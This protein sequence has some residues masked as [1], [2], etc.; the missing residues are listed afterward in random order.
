MKVAIVLLS[1]AAFASADLHKY[2]TAYGYLT[3]FGIP[4]A[5]KIRAQEEEY[6]K[7]PISRIFNGS[8][9]AVGQFKYQAGLIS[10]I[11][12]SNG[13][14]VCGGVLI[15]GNRVL[16]A[17]H[18]WF[19]GLNRAWR[20][21]VVLGSLTLF[22]GGTRLHSTEV[23]MHDNWFPLLTRNDIAVI[24]LP[25]SVELTNNIDVIA[26]PTGDFAEETFEGA[27]AT[28]SGFGMIGNDVPIPTTQSL[29][30]G[31]AHVISNTECR[32]VF[33]QVQDTNICL[34]TKGASSPCR[35]D[36][37]GPLVVE[38]NG[39]PVLIG[40]T[41]FGAHPN[42]GGCESGLPAVFARVTSYKDFI[43]Q[44]M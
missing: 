36:S 12:G 42:I 17:A 30:Y 21:E 10:E 38:R 20:V 31:Q 15:S 16:T 9:A 32:S 29:S 26:L 1:L 43:E 34:G 2:N 27:L 25:S 39:S 11:I 14:G 18:C 41:S 5:E 4:L 33:W 23:V 40:L 6:L 22:T 37:G 28:A 19:D 13:R 44:H 24:Y 35:G 3:R 7:N 8:P